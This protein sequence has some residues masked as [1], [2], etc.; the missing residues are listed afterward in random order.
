[1]NTTDIK[2]RLHEEIEHSDEK[3]LKMIYALVKE[4][5]EEGGDDITDERKKLIR[6]ERENYLQGKGRSYSWDEVKNMAINRQGAN[7]L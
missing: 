2:S 3:L 1:M 7:E 5:Q 6:A 4:Y